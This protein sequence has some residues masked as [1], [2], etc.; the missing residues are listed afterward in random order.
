[1]K[2][3]KFIRE[4]GMVAIG[5]SALGN[6]TWSKDRFTGDTTTTTDILGP[7]YRPNAPLRSNINPPDYSGQVFH[8]SG[9]VFKEDGQ[10]PFNNALVEIWQCDGNKLYDNVSDEFRYRGSQRTGADG[11]YHFTGMHPIPYLAGESTEIW[12][13]AHI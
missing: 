2:R 1:M 10:T 7:F 11:K 3:R 8:I 5:V 6:V 9:T 4:T 13:P 12:R